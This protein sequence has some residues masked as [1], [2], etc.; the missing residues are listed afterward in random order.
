MRKLRVLIVTTSHAK[1][2]GTGERTGVWLE[3]LAGPYF[4][5]SDAGV[6]ITVASIRGGEIPFDPRSTVKEKSDVP[7]PATA[8]RFLQDSDAMTAAKHSL[9]V[10]E[11]DAASSDAIY[12]PDGHGAMWD[13]PHS[14]PLARIVASV[15]DTGRIVS[16]DRSSPVCPVIKITTP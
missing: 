10:D 15:F 4:V 12:L 7:V 2:G 5:L 8:R 13:M 9:S 3:E 11:V 6:E 14:L 16:A 1:L